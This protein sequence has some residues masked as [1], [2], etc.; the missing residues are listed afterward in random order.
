MSE[1]RGENIGV[2]REN[3]VWVG[4]KGIYHIGIKFAPTGRPERPLRGRPESFELLVMCIAIIVIN[5]V[6]TSSIFFVC[7][8]YY[9]YLRWSMPAWLLAE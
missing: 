6:L 8:F 4:N 3:G 2:Y 7:L 5:I 1:Y 9:Y